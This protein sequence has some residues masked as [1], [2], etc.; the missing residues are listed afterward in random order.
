MSGRIKLLVAALLIGPFAAAAQDSAPNQSYEDTEIPGPGLSELG[1]VIPPGVDGEDGDKDQDVSEDP[2]IAGDTET[3]ISIRM[4]DTVPAVIDSVRSKT[5]MPDEP[6]SHLESV[7]QVR[8]LR[9]TELEGGKPALMQTLDEEIRA[10]REEL[11][12]ALDQARTNMIVRRAFEQEGYSLDNL[13]TWET[14]GTTVATFV[15]D[16]RPARGEATG[17]GQGS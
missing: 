8:I 5:P 1:D 2:Y 9:L 12:V 14:G 13:L 7:S 16:D 4:L 11:E 3:D 6:L 17:T 10:H 15:V